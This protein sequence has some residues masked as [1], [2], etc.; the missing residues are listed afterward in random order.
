VN[1]TTPARWP[2]APLRDAAGAATTAVLA[3]RLDVSVRTVWRWNHH[4]LSDIQADHA[5]IALGLHPALVWSDWL[6][7]ASAPA[8]R[9]GPTR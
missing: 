7:A 3:R 5:A 6:T 8:L 9:A 4:G 1:T 2:L